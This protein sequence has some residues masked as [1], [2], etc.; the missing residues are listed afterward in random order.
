[1]ELKPCPFCG[2][3]SIFLQRDKLTK[4]D[5]YYYYCCYIKCC[6]CGACGP[7]FVSSRECDFG[8]K[9]GEVEEFA[10]KSWN[11]RH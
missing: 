5:A 3:L 6:V 8:Y 1:M 11:E 4:S 2:S 10:S 9:H 7:K